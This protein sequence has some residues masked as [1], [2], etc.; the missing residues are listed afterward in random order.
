MTP[1]ET[2]QTL[3]EEV[4]PSSVPYGSFPLPYPSE[5]TEGF[6]GWICEKSH[7]KRRDVMWKYL[8]G[9]ENTSLLDSFRE[10]KDTIT[11][12]FPVDQR[13][14]I[15]GDSMRIDLINLQSLERSLFDD[16]PMTLSFL[17][18]QLR[19]DPTW[20]EGVPPRKIYPAPEKLK[21]EARTEPKKSPMK[22]INKKL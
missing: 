20:W 19:Y 14:G 9:T 5:A 2:E 15:K 12:M 1:A 10:L 18:N 3:K 16:P 13:T 22:L 6:L 11:E 17:A 7:D 4:F 8:P 21:R